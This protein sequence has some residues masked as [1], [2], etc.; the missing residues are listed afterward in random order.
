VPVAALLDRVRAVRAVQVHRHAAGVTI[1][2]PTEVE[3][4]GLCVTEACEGF[5]SSDGAARVRQRL[6]GDLPAFGVLNVRDRSLVVTPPHSP[7]PDYRRYFGGTLERIARQYVRGRRS[8][9]G[10]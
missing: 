9:F 2:N 6:L 8:R 5:S 10:W 7:R 4:S 1:S 3:L